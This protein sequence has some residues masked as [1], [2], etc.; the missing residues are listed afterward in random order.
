[1]EFLYPFFQLHLGN[2]ELQYA[3]GFIIFVNHTKPVN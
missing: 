1:M 3:F 2:F